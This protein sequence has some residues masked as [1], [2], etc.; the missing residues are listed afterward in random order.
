MFLLNEVVKLIIDL[1][2]FFSNLIPGFIG[3]GFE[4]YGSDNFSNINEDIFFQGS[5]IRLDI[6]LKQMM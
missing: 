6:F 2:D 1:S 4:G 3:L 5:N